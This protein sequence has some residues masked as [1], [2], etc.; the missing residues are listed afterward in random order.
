MNR[1]VYFRISQISLK[2]TAIILWSDAITATRILQ[3]SHASVAIIRMTVLRC[4][5]S[6]MLS[7]PSLPY[8]LVES[9]NDP[10]ELAHFTSILPLSKK[11]AADKLCHPR[12]SWVASRSS[13]VESF[14]E[15]GRFLLF[16]LLEEDIARI[17]RN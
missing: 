9:M 2:I 8:R 4:L 16:L 14:S 6:S 12:C 10:R 17:Q 11:S 3:E 13:R 5:D 7:Q 15:G 1:S